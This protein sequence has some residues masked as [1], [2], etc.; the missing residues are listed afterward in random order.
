MPPGATHFV[1][2]ASVV[3]ILHV[4]PKAWANNHPDSSFSRAIL[5]IFG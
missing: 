2:I 1:Y 3:V 4:F 5:A